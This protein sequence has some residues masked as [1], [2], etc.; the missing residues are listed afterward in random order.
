[1]LINNLLTKTIESSDNTAIVVINLYVISN[2]VS[3]PE[4]KDAGAVQQ[5]VIDNV[6]QHS[7]SVVKQL[8]SFIAYNT[9]LANN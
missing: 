6:W 7:L 3:S 1:M 8:F 4:S 5:I 9:H 2:A